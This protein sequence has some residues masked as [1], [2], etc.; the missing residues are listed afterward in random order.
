LFNR[1]GERA[2]R[3]LQ[4]SNI[5]RGRCAVAKM[6]RADQDAHLRREPSCFGIDGQHRN[7][8]ARG[9]GA[10]PGC[11]GTSSVYLQTS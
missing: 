6:E 10:V 5:M 4:D 11:I 8:R 3:L 2:M 9:F 1:F 7:T